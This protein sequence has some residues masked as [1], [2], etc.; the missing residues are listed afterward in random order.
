MTLTE[1]ETTILKTIAAEDNPATDD[2]ARM[3]AICDVIGDYTFMQEERDD[4]DPSKVSN[5][6]AAMLGLY[7]PVVAKFKAQWD[8]RAKLGRAAVAS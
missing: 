4:L 5:V 3:N 7:P 8:E 6:A 2:S 1:L